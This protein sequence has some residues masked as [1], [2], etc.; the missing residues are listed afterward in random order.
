MIFYEKFEKRTTHWRTFRNE[1]ESIENPLDH[2][3]RFWNQ[4]PISARTC[5]PY[6]RSTWPEAWQL[7]EENKYCD[8]GKIL[9]IYY[10]ISLTDRFSSSKFEIQVAV[11]RLAQKLY[12]LLFIDDQVIGYLYDRVVHISELPKTL[13]IQCTFKMDEDQY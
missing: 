4:A 11:D 3:I 8:F 1:L 6:D 2:T 12:Y 10:T 7:L 5:D 13:E 9:A